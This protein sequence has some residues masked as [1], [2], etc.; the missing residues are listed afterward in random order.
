MA[1]IDDSRCS[2]GQRI[3]QCKAENKPLQATCRY[4]DVELFLDIWMNG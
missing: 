4:I 3:R 1:T 2:N